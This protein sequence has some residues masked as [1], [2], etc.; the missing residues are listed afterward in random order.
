MRRRKFISLLGGAATW[1]L[2]AHA[3]HADR[4]RTV[5]VLIGLAEN[6]P[7]TVAR[8]KAFRLGMR[9]LGSIEGRN[10]QIDYRFAGRGV[11]KQECDGTGSAN[12]RRH[13]GKWQCDHG[14]AATSD[15]YHSNRIRG[16]E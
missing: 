7:E 1:P 15:E 3:Q 14:C 13:C 10:V 5:S 12:A 9:D 8:L 6:D 4:M 2:A 16:G 11:D